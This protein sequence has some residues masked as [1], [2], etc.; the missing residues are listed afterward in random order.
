MLAIGPSLRHGDLQKIVFGIT[1]MVKSVY[2][3][4]SYNGDFDKFY[5]EMAEMTTTTFTDPF[6]WV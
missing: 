3:H 5:S 4:I 2:K 1:N 6:D